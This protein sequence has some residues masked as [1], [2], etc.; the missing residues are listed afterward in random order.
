MACVEGTDAAG[1]HGKAHRA[2]GANIANQT[3]GDAAAGAA[4]I[5]CGAQELTPGRNP[6]IAAARED[7]HVV[8]PQIVDQI[9]LLLIDVHCRIVVMDFHIEAGARPAAEHQSVI[10]RAD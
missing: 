5:G 4:S 10:Q 3:I 2:N 6:K 7:S 9:D 8:R 1:E